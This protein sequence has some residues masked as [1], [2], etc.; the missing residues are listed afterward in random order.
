[1]KALLESY[2][3]QAKDLIEQDGRID[4][5]GDRIDSTREGQRE[6]IARMEKALIAV[7]KTCERHTS[8]V[9]DKLDDQA[10]AHAEAMKQMAAAHEKAMEER[11]LSS[12]T[13]G[14]IIIAAI[15]G[16]ATII[17]AL[18]GAFPG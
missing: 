16:N 8:R 4:R 3:E 2:G 1:M 13:K 5:L 18:I 12:A 15:A 10:A 17:A 7:G 11:G 14:G 9:A 6:A